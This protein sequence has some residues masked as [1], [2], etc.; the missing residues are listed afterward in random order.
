ML[1]PLLLLLFASSPL[2]RLSVGRVSATF[3]TRTAVRFAHC[4]GLSAALL[5]R[6]PSAVTH[7][8]SGPGD[9]D[10][11]PQR[12]F[13]ASAPAKLIFFLRSA[14]PRAIA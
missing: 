4:L 2:F 14:F 9:L 11:V 12:M 13:A 3:D 5:L 6:P 7:C 8:L 1:V 10:Y